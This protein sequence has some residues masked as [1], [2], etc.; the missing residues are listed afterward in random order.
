MTLGILAMYGVA[1]IVASS[2]GW[3]DSKKRIWRWL[4]YLGYFVMFAVFVHALSVG[5]DVRY[6]S[7]RLAWI[8]LIALVVI[9]VVSRL[10]RAG[11]LRKTNNAE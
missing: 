7:F 6:G 3:I 8:A 2:L 5:T 9:A 4:H 10:L 1:I 11:T